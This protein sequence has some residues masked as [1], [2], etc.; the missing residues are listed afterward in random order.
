LR[1]S[2]FFGLLSPFYVSRSTQL[3]TA[4]LFSPMKPNL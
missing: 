3:F 1:Y 4:H 2:M